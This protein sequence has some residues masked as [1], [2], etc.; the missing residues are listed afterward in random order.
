MTNRMRR[1]VA[2][3]C[4]RARLSGWISGRKPG[5]PSRRSG[6]MGGTNGL[7]RWVTFT[8]GPAVACAQWARVTIHLAFAAQRWFPCEVGTTPRTEGNS[9]NG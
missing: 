4:P 1:N 9:P 3:L 7:P 8:N 6:W 5:R 2:S